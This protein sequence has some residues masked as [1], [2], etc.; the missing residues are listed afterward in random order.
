MEDIRLYSVFD[1]T[2]Q[3][4]SLTGLLGKVYG[5]D[6]G[7]LRATDETYSHHKKNVKKNKNKQTRSCMT[8]CHLSDKRIHKEYESNKSVV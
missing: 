5:L 7:Q 8:E 1:F 2:Q 3:S 6:Q 4:A